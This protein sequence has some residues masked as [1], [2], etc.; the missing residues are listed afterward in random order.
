LPVEVG[1]PAAL[2]GEEAL[3]D[4]AA[5]AGLERVVHGKIPAGDGV[6]SVDDGI[7]SVFL[8]ALLSEPT[9][10]E[11][12]GELAVLFRKNMR[13]DPALRVVH[14]ERTPTFSLA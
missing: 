10:A 8:V 1:D 4:H 3:Q 14:F 11:D 5:V 9:A 2:G 6:E 12:A 7:Q 13:P